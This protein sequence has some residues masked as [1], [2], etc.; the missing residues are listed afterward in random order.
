MK[1]VIYVFILSILTITGF[2]QVKILEVTHY[3]FPEFTNGLVLMKSGVRNE[4][5]LNYNSLTEE[6]IF[7]N[8]GTKLALNQLELI[9]TI[10]VD[11][12]KFFPLN[13]KFVE[14]IFNS[15]YCLIGEN[16]CSLKGPGKPAA[17]GGTSETS[18]TTTYSSYFSSGQVY[19]LK[20][21]ENYETKPYTDYL[22]KKDG[23]L[24]KFISIRQLAKLFRDKEEIFKEYVSK[25]DVKYDNQE[26]LVEL[27]RF[28]EVN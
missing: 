12:R 1:Q 18:A 2:A 14:L 19:E 10:Y 28:L 8:K 23:K 27:I 24:N 11:N 17:Y 21:P 26:S 13:N 5:L 25:H 15:K 22:L 9:D 20:L 3:L 6:M 7:E 16:K 4:V